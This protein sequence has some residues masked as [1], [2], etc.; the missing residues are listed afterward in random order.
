MHENK[1]IYIDDFIT[2]IEKNIYFRDVHYFMRRA[3]DIVTIKRVELV[4]QNLWICLRE[5]VLKWWTV[6]FTN[7]E[8]LMTTF[9]AEADGKLQQWTR[10]L[11]DCFKAFFNITLNALFNERYT[12]RDVV[13]RRELKKY[14]QKI[15]LLTKNA[16][17][18]SAKNQLNII[19]NDIDNS[20]RKS[21]VKRSKNDDIVN[22]M[23]KL[24]NDC[25]HD[26]WDY[27]AKAMREQ[28]KSQSQTQKFI[29]NDQYNF[30][31][32]SNQ[33]NFQRRSFF[34]SVSIKCL[35]Q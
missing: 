7:N 9:T 19:Y 24:L 34:K 16:S 5:I 6:E 35:F 17:L 10:L 30:N 23:L 25:K 15:L 31:R 28:D 22:S 12:L 13:N 27:E 33:S 18:D 4:R 20:L 2:Q 11:H 21:D 26:W 29:Q 32:N 8:R 1:S 14:I 3:N